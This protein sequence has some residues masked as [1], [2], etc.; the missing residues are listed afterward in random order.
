MEIQTFEIDEV[1]TEPLVECEE[2]KALIEKLG[3]EGQQTLMTVTDDGEEARCPYRRMTKQEFDVY[4][5]LCPLK[6]RL[7]EY[8]GQTI[9]LRVLQVASHADSLNF[10]QYIQVWDKQEV[11]IKDPVLV[12]VIK[13]DY[14]EKFYILARWGEELD[15]MPAMMKKAVEMK[16][17]EMKSD[18]ALK[19]AAL[20]LY[21]EKL[22][23]GCVSPSKLIAARSIAMYHEDD[24]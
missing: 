14:D 22:A 3:L 19:I 20:K 10:F 4:S 23:G 17:E 12:G 1:M 11:E 2:S 18:A 16:L 7:D 21:I 5:I 24:I 6:K 13:E 15:E 8:K 9:P